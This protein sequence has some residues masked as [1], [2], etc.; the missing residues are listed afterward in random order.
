M[1]LDITGGILSL[2]QIFIDGAN[3]GKINVF[4]GGGAFNIAK[5]CL[6][7]ITIV[8]DILFMIQHYILY[9]PKRMVAK[10]TTNDSYFALENI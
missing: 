2:L 10:H 1:L 6:S 9:N 4:G 8:F 5:F 7:I 3:T